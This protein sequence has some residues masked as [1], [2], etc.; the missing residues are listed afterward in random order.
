MN[1]TGKRMTECQE[2]LYILH[3]VTFTGVAGREKSVLFQLTE[4]SGIYQ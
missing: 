3:G 1:Q 4:W 2:Y